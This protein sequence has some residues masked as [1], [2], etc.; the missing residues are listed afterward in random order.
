MKDTEYQDKL[1]DAI[2]RGDEAK[3]AWKLV[4]PYFAKAQELYLANLVTSVRTK[5]D[6]EE[7]LLHAV[8]LAALEDVMSQ[9]NQEAVS[10]KRAQQEANRIETEAKNAES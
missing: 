6:K 10:G 1:L 9:M 4:S 8:K 3:R 7:I 2:F 5:A